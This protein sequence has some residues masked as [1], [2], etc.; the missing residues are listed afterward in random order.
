MDEHGFII[1]KNKHG[2]KERLEYHSNAE[3]RRLVYRL[4][5]KGLPYEIVPEEYFDEYFSKVENHA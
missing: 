2:E 3:Q 1:A 5:N 4:L